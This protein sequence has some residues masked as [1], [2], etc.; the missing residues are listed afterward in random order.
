MLQ[1]KKY[2]KKLI[3]IVERIISSEKIPKTTF[4]PGT[5]NFQSSKK[6]LKQHFSTFIPQTTI[7]VEFWLPVGQK[8]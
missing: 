1:G 3:T 8:C 2:V 5:K 4:K 6:L 7:V